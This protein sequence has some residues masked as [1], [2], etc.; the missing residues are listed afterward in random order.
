MVP[1]TERKNLSLPSDW[2]AAFQAAA[3]REGVTLSA[4]LGAAGRRRLDA[5]ARRSLS[6]PRP[7]GRPP[8]EAR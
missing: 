5:A 1:R 8:K 2:W 4:W 3:R 6:Q 7:M